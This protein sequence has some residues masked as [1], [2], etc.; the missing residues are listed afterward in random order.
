[1]TSLKSYSVEASY[2]GI[3]EGESTWERKPP[4][5]IYILL[6]TEMVTVTSKINGKKMED[7]EEPPK[8]GRQDNP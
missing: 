6:S 4:V 2:I 7:K 3:L 8:G 1:M 5:H